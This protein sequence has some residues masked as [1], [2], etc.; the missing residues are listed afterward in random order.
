VLVLYL[1]LDLGLCSKS[2]GNVEIYYYVTS[3]I[4]QSHVDS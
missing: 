4:E 3:H 2:S 1:D